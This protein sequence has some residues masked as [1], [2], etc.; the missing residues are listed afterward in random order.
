[1]IEHRLLH[2]GGGDRESATL[3]VLRNGYY[4][5]HSIC[6]DDSTCDSHESG[7]LTEVEDIGVAEAD[8]EVR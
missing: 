7:K 6:R 4:G 3:T 5:Y 1:M 2:I 8:G